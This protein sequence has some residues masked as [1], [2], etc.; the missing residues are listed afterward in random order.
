MAYQIEADDLDL[1]SLFE[2][3]FSYR[4][5]AVNKIS[6][7]SASRGPSAI[8]A[9]LVIIAI[10]EPL[11]SRQLFVSRSRADRQHNEFAMI[12]P[13]QE[14]ARCQTRNSIFTVIT[15]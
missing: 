5:K 6:I 15:I 14:N 3:D 2:C 9:L 7:D 10:I 13:Y 11:P 12:S 4:C 1:A 8:A